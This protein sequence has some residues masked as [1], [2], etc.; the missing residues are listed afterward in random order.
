MVTT[1]GAFHCQ[2]LVFDR[3]IGSIR[4][5][6]DGIETAAVTQV[7]LGPLKLNGLVVG[8]T[9]ALDTFGAKAT[10]DDL[11]LYRRAL[12]PEEVLMLSRQLVP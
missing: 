12:G 6:V 4:H 1:D 2:V 9:Q 8:A 3:G 10:V 5:Y 7:S 11:R